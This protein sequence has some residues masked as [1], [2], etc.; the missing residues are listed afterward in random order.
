M[1]EEVLQDSGS[2]V[3]ILLIFRL[4]PTLPLNMTVLDCVMIV[5]V[6]A[7]SFNP[8]VKPFTPQGFRNCHC[9]FISDL[10]SG[11]MAMFKISDTGSSTTFDS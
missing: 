11:L 3:H 1:N 8:N 7:T 2:C 4:F 10:T 9:L 5:K 6:T